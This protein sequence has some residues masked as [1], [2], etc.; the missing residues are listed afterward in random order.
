MSDTIIVDV[1][2]VWISLD[3]V[4]PRTLLTHKEALQLA[5]ELK[6]CAE[7]AKAALNECPW[8]GSDN[9]D[10]LQ[11]NDCDA[12]SV[13]YGNIEEAT[14]EELQKGWFKGN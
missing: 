6:R 10:D 7:K 8:C 9:T 13:D 5:D 12:F 11:C 14:L 1:E 2:G 3:V 4:E